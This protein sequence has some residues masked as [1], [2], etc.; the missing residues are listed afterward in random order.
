MSGSWF[1]LLLGVCAVCVVLNMEPVSAICDPG[2]SAF[3]GEPYVEHE[4]QLYIDGQIAETE[5]KSD[6]E[7]GFSYIYPF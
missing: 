1:G 6:D 2:M 5:Y 7:M 3:S 4:A